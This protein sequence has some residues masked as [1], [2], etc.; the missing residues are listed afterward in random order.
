MKKILISLSIV[1]LLTGCAQKQSI[2]TLTGRQPAA[3]AVTTTQRD[4]LI[5]EITVIASPEYGES[6]DAF[7]SQWPECFYEP[8]RSWTKEEA[9]DCA[10]KIYK[11]RI[12]SYGVEMTYG[13]YLGK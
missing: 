5:P 7:K 1:G 6:T 10:P 2:P 11:T 12:K 3:G 13:E 9:E 8:H 4:I